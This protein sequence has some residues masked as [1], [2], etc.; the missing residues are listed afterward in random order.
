[1]NTFGILKTFPQLK[2]FICYS[3]YDGER[4]R[5]YYEVLGISRDADSKT[6]RSAYLRKCKELHPDGKK[7]SSDKLKWVTEEFMSVRAAYE[8][9]KDCNKRREYDQQLGTPKNVTYKNI[10]GGSAYTNR[11]RPSVQMNAILN[12]DIHFRDF[13]AEYKMFYWYILID[14]FLDYQDESRLETTHT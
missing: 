10:Y 12:E 4:K 5:M 14:G 11:Y 2:S 3:S 1:M 7:L 9:L 13:N 8:I 6:V